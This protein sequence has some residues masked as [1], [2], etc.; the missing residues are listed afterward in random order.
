MNGIS[1]IRKVDNLGMVSYRVETCQQME[2]G[3]EGHKSNHV[4]IQKE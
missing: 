3:F 4:T 2:R 1:T